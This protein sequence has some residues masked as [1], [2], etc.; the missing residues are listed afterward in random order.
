MDSYFENFMISSSWFNNYCSENNLK[1][2]NGQSLEE[3]R[4]KYCH[5]NVKKKFYSFLQETIHQNPFLLYNMDETS[6]S[7]DEKGK[8]VVPVDGSPISSGEQ[9]LGH[10]TCLC[11]CNAAGESLD[12]FLILPRLMNLPEELYE[13][14][15]Q[16]TLVSGPSGWVTSKL[17]SFG[18]CFLL[19]I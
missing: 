3:L 9:K 6:C 11:T 16:C 19:H 2:V 12:P 7:V 8:L 4:R 5:E 15:N 17:F 10:I 14:Q 1:L 18:A 13:L